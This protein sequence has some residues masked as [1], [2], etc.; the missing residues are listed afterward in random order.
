MYPSNKVGYQNRPAK[1]NFEQWLGGFFMAWKK[2]VNIE[3]QNQKWLCEGRGSGHGS[4][5]K[6]WLTIRDLSSQ[7]AH[8]VLN[9]HQ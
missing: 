9:R 1:L 2:N 8:I 6:P 5:Y 3:L 7:V 4:D